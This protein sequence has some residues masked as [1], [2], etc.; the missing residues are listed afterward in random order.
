MF[1][2]LLKLVFAIVILLTVKISSAAVGI[3]IWSMASLAIAGVIFLS[4]FVR[5]LDAIAL[6][7]GRLMA[8]GGLLAGILLM[9]AG[10]IGGSFHL[11][12][13]NQELLAGLVLMTLFGMPFFFLKSERG[14]RS[15]IRR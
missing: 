10:T 2:Q 6:I 8:V 14:E 5:W 3:G 1:R 11:S 15:G 7:L 4:L 9:L 13:S 12:P